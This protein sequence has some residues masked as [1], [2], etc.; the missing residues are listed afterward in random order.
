[1]INLWSKKNSGADLEFDFGFE[2]KS[3]KSKNANLNK[4]KQAK[5]DE[6]YTQLSDIESELSRYP[7]DIFKDK[8]VYCP[9]D[10]QSSNFVKYFTEH[11]ELGIKKLIHTSIQEG[12]DFRSEYCTQLLKEADI[13][14]TNPPFSLFRE[15]IAWLMKYEKK[16]IILGDKNSLNY[17]TPMIRDNKLWLGQSIHSGERYFHQPDSDQLSKG[18]GVRWFT[19]VD[20]QKR[21]EDIILYMTYTGNEDNYPKYDNYDAIEVSKTKEIPVDYDGIMGVPITFLDKYNPNQFEIIGT[22]IA[23]YYDKD[24]PYYKPLEGKKD[25]GAAYL[26]GKK[27]YA[28]ILIRKKAEI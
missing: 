12:Y 1:M 24:A 10:M 16:F 22:A 2:D 8:I 3:S 20:Y 26:R 7:K 14:V 4:A 23:G 27:L 5:N 18:I 28:R 15:F 25:G 19:N 17:L 6:F 11:K 13:V 21:Y 9:C